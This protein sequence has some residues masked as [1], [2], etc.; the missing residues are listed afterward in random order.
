MWATQVGVTKKSS[1][2]KLSRG[3]Y[4]A[5]FTTAR[6]LRIVEWIRQTPFPCA[7]SNETFILQVW[8][9]AMEQ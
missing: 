2:M 9:L 5:L 6:F 8:L 4:R 1:G 3:I 7:K